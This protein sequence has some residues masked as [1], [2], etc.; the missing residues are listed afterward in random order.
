M[1]PSSCHPQ[2]MGILNLTP[3]SFSDGG[4]FNTPVK[5]LKQVK[6]MIK[7]GAD[8]IDLGGES[9]GPKSLEVSLSDELQ[10]V[11]PIIQLIKAEKINIPLSVDTYKA[12][13]AKQALE[14][15]IDMIN[16][17]TAL[18]GDPDMK[19]ILGHYKPYVVLMYAKDD[20][21]RTTLFSQKYSDVVS[22]IK[23]FLLE[24]VR[25][26]IRYGI[27]KEKI[28]LDPGLG[29]FV[30]SEHSYSFEIIRR[31]RE[32][33]E[34]GFPI[35]IGPSRKSFLGGE[36]KNRLIKTIAITALCAYHGAD[37]IRVHDVKQ[38]REAVEVAKKVLI[39]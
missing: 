15:G 27:P 26:A 3:D 18:R 14:L 28:I 16:D 7:E 32:F 33:K 31:L 23:K 4:K 24:R 17:V 39:S 10:R 5:A 11:I 21:P 30:S 36:L 37:Y 19:E 12:E 9:T 8:F 34:L 1:L 20:T 38:N 35:L 2:I 13:V 6:K 22:H 25:I 29:A